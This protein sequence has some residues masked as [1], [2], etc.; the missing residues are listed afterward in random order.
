MEA[1]LQFCMKSISA[2]IAIT[3]LG[4]AALFAEQGKQRSLASNEAVV[5]LKNSGE[6]E[7]LDEAIQLARYGIRAVEDNPQK[8][9]AQNQQ[10]SLKAIFDSKGLHLHALDENQKLY[11]SNWRLESAGGSKITAGELRC[12][13]QRA[14]IVRPNLTEW[15]INRPTG[16]EHGFTLTHRPE[17]AGAQLQLIVAVEGDLKIVVSED[18]QQAQLQDKTSGAKVLDYDKLRAWDAAGTEL[19]ARMASLNNGTQFQLKVDDAD[20]HY[21]L[22]ID[23]TFTQQ[24]FLKASNAEEDDGFGCSVAVS[25]NTAVIGAPDEDSLLDAT[26]NN[27]RNAGAAYV[28]ERNGTTW[29][30]QAILKADAP[31][32]DDEFGEAV[33][34]SEDTIVIGVRLRDGAEND[35]GD[36]PRDQGAAY[37]FVRNED[38]WNQQTIL[39]ASNAQEADEFGNAVA[40]FGNTIVVGAQ[41]EDS[42][43]S[44]NDD[45]ENQSGAAYVFVREG[46]TWSQQAMLKADNTERFDLFGFSVGIDRET[47]VVGARDESSNATGGNDDNSAFDSGAAYV[48]VRNGTIWNQ[49]AFLKADNAETNDEF[50]TSVAISGDII[51]VGAPRE[52][53]SGSDGSDNSIGNSGAIYIFE[54]SG[55][56]WSQ[57]A[58][59]KANIVENGD[60]LGQAL[61]ISGETIV[62]GSDDEDSNPAGGESDN[63]LTSSGAAYVFQRSGT[64]WSQVDFLKASNAGMS[65]RFGTAVAISGD[66]IVVGADEEDSALLGDDDDDSEN[67]SGAAYIFQAETSSASNLEITNI[68]VNNTLNTVTLTWRSNPGITYDVDYSLDL[69]IWEEDLVSGIAHDANGGGLTSQE[70]SLDGISPEGVQR[71]FLR[72]I[73][74]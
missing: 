35:A 68:E 1:N 42:S 49:Q 65:D 67:G 32:I 21:P 43:A 15:F 22:T 50:G 57:E 8:A 4:A 16:L 38:T 14:E 37:V 40:I 33:A 51:A 62:A 3:L 25:G 20:A 31:E 55:T 46:T 53:S 58:F 72:V 28:F 30:Q 26:D 6:Y 19:P 24:A 60:G 63:N 18:G 10:H 9:W 59:I 73:E 69:T 36:R 48:F 66:L 39:M 44:G 61:A 7:S 34:I 74:E 70:I 13:G 71:L 2:N 52:D 45:E 54:R 41:F 27:Q 11:Q 29:I 47:I 12:N 17:E 56:I 5:Y 64:T 23:P